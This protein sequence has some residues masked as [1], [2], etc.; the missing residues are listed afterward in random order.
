L[1]GFTKGI[2]VMANLVKIAEQA[3]TS[4][5][6]V[7]RV[8]NNKGGVSESLRKK[9]QK[10]IE[11]NG[12]NM[13]DL[14]NRRTRLLVVI[15]LESPVIDC[16]CA[17]VLEGIGTY[18]FEK[19]LETN[20]VFMPTGKSSESHP[21]LDKVKESNCDAI[22]LI[23]G[24]YAKSEF[25]DM[26]EFGLPIMLI[27]DRS[28][29]KGIGYLDNDSYTGSYDAVKYLIDLGHRNIG[30]LCE[31]LK[32]IDHQQRLL[33]Y[34]QAMRD[35]GISLDSRWVVYHTPTQESMEAGRIQARHLMAECPDITA[36]F[37][38]NDSKAIG[39][40]SAL[41][42]MGYKVPDDV[43]VCGFDDL[44]NSRYLVPSLT[45]V[46]QPITELG[47]RAAKYLDMFL[48]GMLKELPREILPTELVV[49]K[50]TVPPRKKQNS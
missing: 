21:V 26:T 17:S 47:Y 1:F 22:L 11:E 7:S 6:T 9:V 12:L 45:T 5:A 34:R 8:V 24:Q 44:S 49:R 2:L 16:F 29:L 32:S 18:S 50:S 40:L 27:N 36:I 10:I 20:I 41:N 31:D 25:E 48:Q 42:Q 46:R 19:D 38:S 28:D 15:E 43:S 30:F 3:S 37:A 13:R 14:V 33:G 23:F 39:V 4:I 35:S